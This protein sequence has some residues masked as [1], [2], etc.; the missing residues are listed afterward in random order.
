VGYEVQAPGSL[1]IEKR[2]EFSVSLLQAFRP[3]GRVAGRLKCFGEQ[4]LVA[5]AVDA[6]VDQGKG[7]VVFLPDERITQG[8]EGLDAAGAVV[9]E[10]AARR[11]AART[12]RER[13]S[14]HGRASDR[15]SGAPPRGERPPARPAPDC[16]RRRRARSPT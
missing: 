7:V 3:G 13:K 12:I 15:G 8:L 6:A 4:G 11:G 14:G 9:E 10:R 1:L 2:D 5:R 16:P